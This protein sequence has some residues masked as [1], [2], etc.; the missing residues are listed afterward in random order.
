VEVVAGLAEGAVVLV[1]RLAKPAAASARSNP[2][3]PYRR[4]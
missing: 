4:R 1:P 2:L 3:N